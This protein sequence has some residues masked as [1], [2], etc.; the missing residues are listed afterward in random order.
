MQANILFRQKTHTINLAQAIDVSIPL[1]EGLNTVNAFY[2][3]LLRI[4]PVRAGDFVGDMQEGGLLNFKN[5]FFS[6]HGN[7]THTECVGHISPSGYTINACLKQFFFFAQLVSIY[8]QRLENGDRMIT[9]AQI[10]EVW[11][12]KQQA[13]A[14]IIRT[15]PNDDWK[16]QTN[17]SGAN[18]PYL[19]ESAIQ[20]I[21]EQNIKHLLLDLP[22]VD[23]EQDDGQL[24]GHKAFWQYPSDKVRLDATITEFVYVPNEVKDDFYFLNLQIASFELDVSPSKPVLYR[25]EKQE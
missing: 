13:P 9:K 12:K 25:I 10:E 20:F 15:L 19:H 14:L 16:F 17:Y 8:P 22:S 24:L 11:N 4:E 5:V 2:A 3:P 1:K 7:G 23:R 6:P 18:P 21:V